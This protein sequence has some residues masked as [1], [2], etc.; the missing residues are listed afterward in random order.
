MER[1]V[2][3]EYLGRSDTPRLAGGFLFSESVYCVG[4][5][6]S[7]HSHENPF[8]YLVTHGV[9]LDRA[10]SG[11]QEVRQKSLLFHPAGEGH[12]NRWGPDG[13]ACF[14]IELLPDRATD[15]IP[16]RRSY[17][18][19]GECAWLADRVYRNFLLA[20]EAAPLAMEGLTLEILAELSRASQPAVPNSPPSWLRRVRD[21]LH[22]R[23]ADMVSVGEIADEAG[24]H[25]SH[26][27]RAFRQHYHATIG[28][29]VRR[30]RVEKSKSLLLRSGLSL[31]EIA[32]D[33]G[34]VDQSHF[35]RVFRQVTGQ[36]PSEYRR[37]RS[38]NFHT[39]D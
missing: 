34:F 2:A 11:E 12:A 9:C 27:A 31:A 28:E 21:L 24:V 4:A 10:A 23:W 3:G 38:R 39:N 37:T 33:A 26:L 36:T 32:L 22:D 35:T 17:A 18:E 19:R 6:L 7:Q 25:P 13:G 14:H 29:Y 20:D 8:L 1:L 16:V 5:D 15:G 30:L